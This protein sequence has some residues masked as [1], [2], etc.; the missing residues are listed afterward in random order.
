[1][2][3]I[4]P[5]IISRPKI[6]VQPHRFARRISGVRSGITIAS[7]TVSERGQGVDVER[8]ARVVQHAGGRDVEEHVD[9]VDARRGDLDFGVRRNGGDLRGERHARAARRGRSTR[10]NAGRWCASATPTAEP[11][12]AGA[13]E[14]DALAGER[15]AAA[16]ERLHAA[17][18]VEDLAGPARR[19]AARAR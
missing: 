18:A 12:A 7:K 6:V 10:T 17:Q 19:R 8:Q 9:V 15:D 1:M 5:R 3:S 2:R 16:A 13:D 11:G 14:H 4:W